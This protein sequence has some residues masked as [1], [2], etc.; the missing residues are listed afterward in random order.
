MKAAI[1]ARVSSKELEGCSIPAQLKLL[2]EQGRRLVRY[3]GWSTV[4][5]S[6][7]AVVT[8]TVPV[9]A[10]PRF[11]R[12][13]LEKL[14]GVVS[15]ITP[16][17]ATLEV[18]A[19]EQHGPAHYVAVALHPEGITESYVLVCDNTGRVLRVLSTDDYF[20][21][22]QFLQLGEGREA[23]VING[24]GGM[25]GLYHTL[26]YALAPDGIPEQTL[27][28]IRGEVVQVRQEDTGVTVTRNF[29]RFGGGSSEA[30][31]IYRWNGQQFAYDPQ[32]S[33]GPEEAWDVTHVDR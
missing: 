21:G 31:N 1:Y 2:R 22:W 5:G 26:I 23:V 27:L 10:E 25:R 29:V 7:L 17:K 32:S 20:E 24:A 28:E 3:H 18:L 11:D 4:L 30:L 16:E 14:A 8:L 9:M 6:M 13:D 19:Y 15:W 33:K 12:I